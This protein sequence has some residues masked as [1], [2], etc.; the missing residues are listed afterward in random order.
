MARVWS[1]EREREEKAARCSALK[2]KMSG[3][4]SF[5]CSCFISCTTTGF[6]K[7]GQE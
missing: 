5:F 6:L 2:L 4:I 7:T 3:G 1:E